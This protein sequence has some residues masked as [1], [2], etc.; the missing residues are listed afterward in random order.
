MPSACGGSKGTE[1]KAQAARKA[2]V[3]RE[4][5]RERY[6]GGGRRCNA[7]LATSVA[8]SRRFSM[9]RKRLGHPVFLLVLAAMAVCL[10]SR[11]RPGESE[12]AVE[13]HRRRPWRWLLASSFLA[14][15]LGAAAVLFSA[16]APAPTSEVAAALPASED[17]VLASLETEADH[18]LCLLPPTPE[19]EEADTAGS[20]LSPDMA[21]LA[22]D[23]EAL[24]RSL[25]GPDRVFADIA[26]AVLDL[27]SGEGIAIDGDERHLAGCTIKLFP[28][29]KAVYD[30][31]E[32]QR[33]FDDTLDYLLQRT[34]RVSNNVDSHYLI[35]LVG[36]PETNAFMT[37]VIGTRG[38]IITHAPGY[39]GENTLYD[40][41]EEENYL[42]ANDL[43][44][45]F[46]K[47]YRGELTTPE[48]TSHLLD[49]MTQ[50]WLT[51][52]E[53]GVILY[54]AAP[55]Q[56]RIAHKIGYVGPPWNVWNDAGVVMFDR[57]EGTVA[58]AV[59][60]LTQYNREYDE[61]P[62]TAR[63]IADR[64]FQYFNETYGLGY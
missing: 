5:A 39:Y 38:S 17:L 8:W 35:D 23:L 52:D 62:P 57:P 10:A 58:Y 55:P 34:V 27:Q 33:E 30:V 37:D 28:A 44:L 18:L 31:R 12:R 9:V 6:V 24:V 3:K 56:A 32:G 14:L 40:I 7:V 25:E 16:Y 46:T 26:V 45:A 61:G 48:L 59:A 50:S 53:Y 2:G 1:G 41:A 49:V 42:T 64:V 43:V 21:R 13:A 15:L 4:V 54:Q 20:S 51:P 60:I 36:V 29:L 47:L 63:Q 22:D 19:S 11:R